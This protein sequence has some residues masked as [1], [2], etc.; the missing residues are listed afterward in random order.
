MIAE[1]FVIALKIKI[2][3]LAIL[4]VDIY[5]GILLTLQDIKPNLFPSH[6]NVIKCVPYTLL[7]YKISFK[8]RIREIECLSLVSLSTSTIISATH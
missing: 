3:K 1:R 5:I 6:N 8:F 4:N 7:V 2:L